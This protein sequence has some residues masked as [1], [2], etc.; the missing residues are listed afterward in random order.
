MCTRHVRQP[1]ATHFSTPTG[2][3][4]KAARHLALNLQEPAWIAKV[5]Y[6]HFHSSTCCVCF[7]SGLV[8][9]AHAYTPK[10]RQG[11]IQLG[12]SCAQANRPH[13]PMGEGR[14]FHKQ[15]EI[16]RCHESLVC[17]V[18]LTQPPNPNP[19]TNRV[20]RVFPYEGFRSY[21]LLNKLAA[22]PLFGVIEPK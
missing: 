19:V 12:G 18:T 17:Y 14:R 10:V 4:A 22:G 7:L 9:S 21:V 20:W 6:D 15:C 8:G 11:N 2:P 5:Q 13:D 3:R 16:A 1:C